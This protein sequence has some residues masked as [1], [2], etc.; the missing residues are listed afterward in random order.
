MTYSMQFRGLVSDET[1]NVRVKPNPATS[2]SLGVTWAQDAAGYWRGV[3]RGV[4][5]YDSSVTVFGTVAEMLAFAEWVEGNGRG[6]FEV[7]V[8]N[9]Q[10]FPPV[11]DQSGAINAVILDVDRLRRVFFSPSSGVE[12]VSFTLRLIDPPLVE[13]PASSLSTLRIGHTFEADKSTDRETGFYGDGQV[14]GSEWRSDTGRFVGGFDQSSTEAAAILRYL[15]GASTLADEGRALT[16]SFPSIGVAYPFGFA[17][18]GLPKNCK[19]RN[20]RVER[21][22]LSRWLLRLELVE[23]A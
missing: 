12:E 22:S 16:F 23:A 18:G 21:L 8:F 20:I 15:V 2:I 5:F 13:T 14:F 19:C 3:D 7:S 4:D 6:E 11:V 1:V 10:L 9:G 17:R